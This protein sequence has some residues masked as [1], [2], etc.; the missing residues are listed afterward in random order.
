M[1]NV[2]VKSVAN[3]LPLH[4]MNDRLDQCVDEGCRFERGGSDRVEKGV[5]YN[6]EDRVY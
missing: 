5:D 2:S 4:C 6:V 3:N 1:E